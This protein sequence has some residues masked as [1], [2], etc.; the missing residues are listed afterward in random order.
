MR[1]KDR[2]DIGRGWSDEFNRNRVELPIKF[3]IYKTRIRYSD[4]HAFSKETPTA[5]IRSRGH[6]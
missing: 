3:L 4:F 5:R 6:Q 1:V 2:S